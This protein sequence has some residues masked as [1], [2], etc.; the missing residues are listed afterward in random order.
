MDC[1]FIHKAHAAA[2]KIG[3]LQ[4]YD[5]AYNSPFFHE[6]VVNCP[7]PTRT[8]IDSGRQQHILPGLDCAELGIGDNKQLLVAV[9]EKRTAADIDR[10]VKLLEQTSREHEA[11]TT[12]AASTVTH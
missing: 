3:A 2:K 1:I 9:T 5:L 7:V 12:N 6:F 4:G 10:L 11:A 8:I